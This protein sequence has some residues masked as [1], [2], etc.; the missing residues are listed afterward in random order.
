MRKV[1]GLLFVF[2]LAAGPAH[3]APFIWTFSGVA[4]S[5]HWDADDLTGLSYTLRVMTDT[6][7]PDQ[8]SFDDFG[9][10]GNLP[11]EIEI[12][13]LGTRILGNFTFIEQFTTATSDRLRIRG[14][15]NGVESVLQIPLGTLGD[16]DFLTFWGPVQTLGVGGNLKITDPGIPNPPFELIDLDNATSRITVSTGSIAAVPEPPSFALVGIGLLVAAV[17]AARKPNATAPLNRESSLSLV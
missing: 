1:V 2:L 6:L 10:Y 8:N 9:T 16:P 4:D 14:P 13:T 11:A 5:G 15:N 12:E 7:A 3:A 17:S